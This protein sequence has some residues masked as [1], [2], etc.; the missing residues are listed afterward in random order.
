M[1]NTKKITFCGIMAAIS[2]VIMLTS[3]F[4]YLTY[5][6]PAIASIF[7]LIPTLE[8]GLK[9]G[10]LTYFVSAIIVL[11]VGE[12]EAKLLFTVFLGY[13]PIVKEAVERHLSKPLQYIIKFVT[14][15]VALVAF[16]YLSIKFVGIPTDEFN[17][18]FKYGIYVLVI[19]A[20]ITFFVY[21]LAL[22]RLINLYFL[23]F[24]TIFNKLLK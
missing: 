22:K 2:V 8:I 11:L 19:L 17:I 15:N 1:S 10:T 5:A 12:M 20:N 16:Y 9:W 24:H 18:G 7:V 3:Y 6:I 23:R 13:Y 14:F 4:P 21:D